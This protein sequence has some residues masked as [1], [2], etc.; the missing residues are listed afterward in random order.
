MRKL[1]LLAAFLCL[2]LISNYSFSQNIRVNGT[3]LTSNGEPVNGATVAVKGT[4]QATF[5]TE[6]GKFALSAKPGAVLIISYVGY[7]TQ[8]V[9][10][11]RDGMRITLSADTKGL[12]EVVITALGIKKEKKAL[13][14]SVTEVKGDELTQARSVNVANSLV[15]KVAGLNITGTSTGP[16]GS[17][18]ITI[19][20]NGSI[21]G[22]NQ[23]LIVVDGIPLNNDN[24][25]SVGMWGGVDNGDGISSL[26]PDEI[27]SVS[28]LKGGT[29]A[30]L[31]GS[32]ASNGAI[33]VTTK[34]GL[35]GKG[36]GVEINSNYVVEGLL[37]PEF[38]EYQYEYGIG[39]NNSKPLN[40]SGD[41]QSGSW[42]A[43]FDNSNVIQYD[44]VER[45]YSPQRDNLKKFYRPG[46]NFTNSI[47]FTGGGDKLVYRLSMSDLNSRSIM[48]GTSLKRDNLALNLNGTLSKKLSFLANVK[49]IKEKNRNRPRISDSPGNANYTMYVLPNSLDV[50]VMKD[51]KYNDLGNEREWA[52]NPY[53]QNPWFAV[54]DFSTLDT[55]DRIITSFEPKF[56]FTDWLYVKG[57]FGF[58]KFTYR[59]NGV[60]PTG[61]AF[62]PGG[63]LDNKLRDFQETNSEVLIGFNKDLSSAFHLNAIAGGNLMKQVYQNED[64]G[65]GPL[66]IPF[67][68]DISNVS[69]ASRNLSYVYTEQRIN[70]L[71][72][73][74]DLSFNDYLFLNVTGRNDWFS[75]LNPENNNIFYPSVGLSFIPSEA[76]Q[77][78]DFVN[79]LKVRGSWAQ[80][81]GATTPYRLNLNYSLV[82]N[83][84]GAP[85]AQI[86]QTEVPN[87]QLQPL[88]STSSEVG[89]E[90]KL[91]NNR[92]NLDFAIYNRV[93]TKDIVGAS[94]SGTTGYT[95]AVFNVGELT[96][97]GVELLLSYRVVDTKNFTW[98]PSI[99]F[100]Y[101]RNKVVAL[102]EGLERIQVD[103][104][105]S[106]TAYVYQEV[107]KA[108]SQLVG[109]GYTYND[110]GQMVV[111]AQG[112]PVVKNLVSFG[113]GI[114][115]LTGGFN[116]TFRYK[117]ISLGILIDGRFGGKVF[118]GTNSLAYGNGLHQQTAA[119]GVRENGVL[120]P[121]SV[122]EDGSANTTVVTA[123]AYYSFLNGRIGEEF[124]YKSDFVKLRQVIL[125]FAIPA[126]VYAKTPFKGV[127]ISLVGRNLLI[128]K[129]YIPNVDPESTYNNT[130]AQGLE[131]ASFPPTRTIGVNLN[132][133][134]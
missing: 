5:T 4:S 50:D 105:R 6:D 46:G 57:R 99:N 32:R 20:G 55:K 26:N 130:N 63:G 113:T 22:N 54:E 44:G 35:K 40:A 131:F 109:F 30:A 48:P 24:L 75:T 29:A 33:L 15:G 14:Y 88:V 104:P 23:P 93:T 67:F 85:L 27:E 97:K 129:K 90:A 118:S 69:P 87:S 82:A 73:S 59:Y 66:N 89:I 80:V 102:T 132:L 103:E 106:R 124:I 34:G 112:F 45:P 64:Y 114:S 71:Y 91:F 117:A 65:G 121:N 58:D 115:P 39:N 70:S 108:F 116:N 110:K 122:K 51:I 56:N 68:Y 86:N 43:K 36:I 11:S 77:M 49:Y 123:N 10:A 128:L 41:E 2:L 42:G 78:P 83:H 3:V 81:G 9:N 31:Y 7:A 101:N 133:K 21:A 111:D 16:G 92:L 76:F 19:R 94:I 28:V 100:G 84:M 74:V 18:R 12:D 107:G 37:L 60:T 95:N 25:G 134:F 127:S 98:E 61:T 96:N 126:R 79:Y 38:K 47:A 13:G 1:Q 52:N 8:E 120:I 119:G 72:G 53:V 62:Q 17:S 125:D